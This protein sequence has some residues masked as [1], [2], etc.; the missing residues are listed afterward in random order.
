[1]VTTYIYRERDK[2]ECVQTLREE[3][4]VTLVLVRYGIG[5]GKFEEEKEER[6]EG[7]GEGGRKEEEEKEEKERPTRRVAY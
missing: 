7:G 3:R 5:V 4:E 6:E 1:M 2:I